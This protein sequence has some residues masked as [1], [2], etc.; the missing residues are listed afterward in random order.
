MLKVIQ[1][2]SEENNFQKSDS[3]EKPFDLNADVQQKYVSIF[4]HVSHTPASTK[5]Q[6]SHINFATS[7]MAQKK[8]IQI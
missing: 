1:K 6:V 5:T 7:F 4:V 3:K 2:Q 8:H